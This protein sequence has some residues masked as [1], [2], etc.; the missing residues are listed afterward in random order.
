[1]YRGEAGDQAGGGGPPAASG[2]A[3]RARQ[4]GL[5]APAVAPQTWALGGWHRPGSP[6]QGGSQ[7]PSRSSAPS[8]ACCRG[9]RGRTTC[10]YCAVA[11]FSP[12]S[13]AGGTPS[14]LGARRGGGEA[15]PQ[16]RL[17][18]SPQAWLCPDL[19]RRD[20]PLPPSALARPGPRSF[21]GGV[22]QEGQNGSIA[23]GG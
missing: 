13:G 20:L 21:R 11:G 2:A 5:P 1:M 22:P 23:Q 16:S 14:V 19:A 12:A 9:Q 3:G 18:G 7:Q 8:R 10:L 15:Q 17:A 4:V 6:G